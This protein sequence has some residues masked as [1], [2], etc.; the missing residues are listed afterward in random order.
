MVAS[1]MVLLHRFCC[2][3]W[4]IVQVLDPMENAG[5]NQT[6]NSSWCGV[7]GADG[8]Q[9]AVMGTWNSSPGG[10]GAGAT[11]LTRTDRLVMVEMAK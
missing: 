10:A 4:R 5:V 1:K 8:S 3:R 2:R 6:G 7:R 11:A 9:I